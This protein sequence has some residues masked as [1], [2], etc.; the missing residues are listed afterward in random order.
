MLNI[1]TTHKSWVTI[2]KK[3]DRFKWKLLTCYSLM[4]YSRF[5]FFCL[6]VFCFLDL[7]LFKA[8]FERALQHPV[9]HI[10][11]PDWIT[12]SVQGMLS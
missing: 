7:F 11:T 2:N 5:G 4:I 12:D 8:K 3:V 10:V 1:N 9:I 6:F